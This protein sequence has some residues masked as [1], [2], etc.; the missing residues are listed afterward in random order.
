MHRPA[1]HVEA[2]QIAFRYGR[3]GLWR[4]GVPV[5]GED[6]RNRLVGDVFGE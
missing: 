4:I 2:L 6:A 1:A 5:Y 3:R